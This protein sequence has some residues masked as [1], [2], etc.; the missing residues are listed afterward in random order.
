MASSSANSASIDYFG[1]VTFGNTLD[2]LVTV[3]L[4]VTIALTT[5]W[6]GSVR[7]E[8][9]LIL[10][11]FHIAL[12]V[13]HGIWFAVENESPKRVSHIPVFF[14][15][16][17]VWSFVHLAWLSPT[18]WTAWFSTLHVCQL[19]IIFWVVMNNVRTRAHVWVLLILALS[20]A[21]YAIFI[22]FYQ[23]FQ[24]PEKIVDSMGEVPL[25]ISPEFVGQSTGTFADPHSFAAFLLI[26]LPPMLIGGALPRLPV[27]VR[28]LCFY[29]A[30]I[31]VVTIALTQVAWAALLLPAIFLSV[32]FLC[33]TTLRKKVVQSLLWGLV[34]S[35]ALGLLIV[36]LPRFQT[37][38]ET[39]MSDDGE[40]IRL[41]LWEETLRLT[42]EHPVAGIGAGSFAYQLENSE[43]TS[44]AKRP[45]TPHNDYLL[46]LSEYGAVGF[47]LLLAP[48]AGILFKGARTLRAEPHRLRAKESKKH[49]VPPQRFFL[50]LGFSGFLAFALCLFF[51]PL[52]LV[53]ALPLYGLLFFAVIAKTSF[54]RGL[55]LGEFRF[56]PLV[57]LALLLGTGWVLYNISFDRLQARALQLQADEKLAGLAEDREDQDQTGEKQDPLPEIIETYE[58]AASLAPGNAEV[59]LG[60]SAAYSQMFLRRPGRAEELSAIAAEHARTALSI[61]GELWRGWAHLGMAE[62]LAGNRAQAEEAL[63]K[64]LELAPNNSNAHYF[65]AAF[66]SNLP[67]GREEAVA[68]VERALEI[69]PGHAP[70]RRLQRKLRIL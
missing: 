13:L 11:F 26:L 8:T 62:A 55:R 31:L 7:P 35:L 43:R 14:L 51:A 63:S 24:N 47:L 23:Y 15:P 29:I 9:Q 64:A 16:F 10:L 33:F 3:C 46:V 5:L 12:L 54:R 34:F 32:P 6:L 21:A 41:N 30:I 25:A 28:I 49:I 44:F 1:R 65:W 19:F 17:V 27:I 50:S 68:A 4:G 36:L 48:A 61:S 2:W 60:L 38:L 67:D 59:H 69:N 56:I 52:S 20:P 18:P 22:G 58:Q 37:S 45:E 66:Q 70:A 42:A 40:R 53:H 39:A 57:Y